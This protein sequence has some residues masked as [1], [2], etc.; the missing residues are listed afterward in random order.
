MARPEYH[1]LEDRNRLFRNTLKDE[2]DGV[3]DHAILR[4]IYGLPLRPVELIRLRT[5]D[6]AT[7]QGKV[8]PK[9]DRVMR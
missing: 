2:S 4:L 9:R 8:L 1:K 5:H 3:R 6:V 7:D